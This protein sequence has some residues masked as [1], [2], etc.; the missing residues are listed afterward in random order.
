MRMRRSELCFELF[1][2]VI[3]K[4]VISNIIALTSRPKRPK[5]EL[6][7]TETIMY[8]HAEDAALLMKQ[9]SSPARLMIL[10]ALESAELSVNELNDKVALSQS[11]LSQH[12]AKLRSA[13]LVSTRKDKQLVFYRLAG[14]DV[15]QVIAVLKSIYC[16]EGSVLMGEE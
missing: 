9:L 6:T 8:R 4:L 2:L 10:C 16:P 5:V 14:T 11:A 7:S 13:G 12:L 3:A 15:S 1:I